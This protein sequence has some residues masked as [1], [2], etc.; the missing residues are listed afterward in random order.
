MPSSRRLEPTIP[1]PMDVGCYAA[2]IRWDI[3][4]KAG[5]PEVTDMYSYLDALKKMQEVY[6]ADGGWPD[7]HTPWAFIPAG[8]ETYMSNAA[9]IHNCH[10]RKRTVE[11]WIQPVQH[12]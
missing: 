6:P 10:G 9:K 4:E 2:N 3:Y 5:K 12:R 11:Y 8:M 1:T 7:G